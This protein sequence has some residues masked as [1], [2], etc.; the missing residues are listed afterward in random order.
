MIGATG[1]LAC[2]C[3]GRFARPN[4]PI[5]I[6][7]AMFQEISIKNNGLTHIFLNFAGLPPKPLTGF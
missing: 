6:S 5:A 7:T 4:A 1:V 3:I 2:T